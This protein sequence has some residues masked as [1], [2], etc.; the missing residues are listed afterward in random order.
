MSFCQNC[1]ARLEE[2]TRFCTSCGAP[3]ASQQGASQPVNNPAAEERP[4]SAPPQQPAMQARPMAPRQ[5]TTQPGQPNPIEA[6]VM[7]FSE[8]LSTFMT[9]KASMIICI[10]C[11]VLDIIYNGSVFHFSGVLE[12][13]TYAFVDNV[14]LWLWKS[15]YELSLIY[16]FINV[17]AACYRIGMRSWLL[18]VT[19]LLWVASVFFFIV[20]VLCE[21]G[22]EDLKWV[23]RMMIVSEILVLVIGVQ[24]CSTR[25][26][27]LGKV[28]IATTIL[29]VI[30]AVA[31]DS[32]IPALFSIL[33]TIYWAIVVKNE[34]T[35][36]Y[37]DLDNAYYQQYN[38]QQ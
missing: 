37:G 7:S 3:V 29:W 15:V 1:G 19:P 25:F 9:I 36:F 4:M 16:L 32:L 2:G 14:P 23:A 6:F 13:L 38:E 34:L 33:A 11:Q 18:Y 24:L 12:D 27:W 31:Q 26:S 5:K 35:K 30:N 17:V 10:L 21:M 8:K 20:A 28:T 22:Y